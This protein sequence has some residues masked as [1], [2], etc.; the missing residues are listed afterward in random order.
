V[1]VIDMRT[2]RWDVVVAIASSQGVWSPDRRKLAFVRTEGDGTPWIW[3]STPTARARAASFAAPIPAGNRYVADQPLATAARHSRSPQPIAAGDHGPTG[4]LD[5]G[6]M[7]PH[8]GRADP[9]HRPELRRCVAAQA[10]PQGA[11]AVV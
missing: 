1:R 6:G 3:S 2:S 8:P 5:L 9:G 7:A 10:A 11:R 4:R